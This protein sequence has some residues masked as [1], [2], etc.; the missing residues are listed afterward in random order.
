M[1]LI[2]GKKAIDIGV[3]VSDIDASLNFYV[4]LLGLEK[5]QETPLWFG[6]MHRLAFGDSFIKLI[7][8]KKTPPK[9]SSNLEDSL[10][11]R[12][13]TLQVSNI[14]ELCEEL[15]R[16]DIEFTLEKK[17]YMPGVTIAMVKDPDG[18]IVEFVERA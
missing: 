1:P 8:P 10:G 11:F 7:D 4:E 3:I 13:L 18:N 15:G 14:D 17:E 16:K 12:Y 5:I 6:M 2:A 9:S